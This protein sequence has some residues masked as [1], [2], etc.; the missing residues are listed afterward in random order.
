MRR[1]RLT[2]L[3]V[4]Q[5]LTVLAG[6]WLAS[7]FHTALAAITA[8]GNVTPDPSTWKISTEGFVG[9]TS[10]GTLTINAGSSLS[11]GAHIGYNAGVT[12]VVTV[13]GGSTWNNYWVN[14]GDFGNGTLKVTNGGVVYSGYYENYNSDAYIGR[15]SGSQ[16]TVLVDGVGS[17]WTNTSG[18]AM[19]NGTLTITNGGTVNSSGDNPIDMGSVVTVNGSGSTWNFSGDSMYIGSSGSGTLNITGGGK[20]VGLG[21]V[22]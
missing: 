16:G 6:F 10:N 17:M 21:D 5:L 14:V 1:R 22:A 13:D 7:S 3:G 18:I 8:S 20:V 15:Y 12:G 11:G 19:F 9:L 4:P 2:V